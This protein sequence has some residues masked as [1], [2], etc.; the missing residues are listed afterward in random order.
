[1][2]TQSLMNF[3]RDS[4]RTG[5]VLGLLLALPFMTAYAMN[6]DQ[7]KSQ[8]M[9]CELPTGYLKPTTSATADVKAMVKDINTKRKA[10]YKR[11][12]KQHKVTVEQVGQLTAQKLQPK[13]P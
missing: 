10:E 7:A 4:L 9:V 12:A 1:M 8:G 2:S 5:L 6:L 3:S 11:I 13:C